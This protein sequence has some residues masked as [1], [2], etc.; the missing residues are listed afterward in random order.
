MDNRFETITLFSEEFEKLKDKETVRIFGKNYEL[1]GF[2]EKFDSYLVIFNKN[3][4]FEGFCSANKFGS[5]EKFNSQGAFNG[6]VSGDK[7]MIK[8]GKSGEYEGYYYNENG[9][10]NEFDVRGAYLGYFK[11]DSNGFVRKYDSMG[12]LELSF[13]KE[14]S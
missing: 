13:E 14:V 10:L 5:F 2:L 12:K 11:K 7:S 9:C 4:I 8:Y 1:Q 6:Y 3:R